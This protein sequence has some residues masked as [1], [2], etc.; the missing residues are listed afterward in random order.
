MRQAWYEANGLKSTRA[1]TSSAR[2][3]TA[4]II[5]ALHMGIV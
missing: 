3:Y 1:S 2:P 5:V 4:F